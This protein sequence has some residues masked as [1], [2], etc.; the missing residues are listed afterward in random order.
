M[1]QATHHIRR[2]EES[3]KRPGR[4]VLLG[5]MLDAT[6]RRTVPIRRAFLQTPKQA[7]NAPRN[8]PLSRLVR[9]P[10]ALDAYLLIHAM[11][12]ASEPYDTWYPVPT[13]AQVCGLTEYAELPA[14]R[15]RWAK[16]VTRLEREQ[17]IARSRSGNRMA[18]LLR[19]ESGSGGPYTRPIAAEHGH[20]F[21][22]PHVYWLHEFDR[23]LSTPEKVMLLISLDQQDDFRLPAD[24]A[25]AWYGISESTA[26][27]GFH[28]LA[29]RGILDVRS[30]ME[31][32]AKS[33][34]GWKETLYY[35]ATGDWS[36]EA[37]TK[38]NSRKT[39]MFTNTTAK[40]PKPRK[41]KK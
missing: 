29:E 18:Y 21:S 2:A 1:E 41:K 6:N 4:L 40:S 36:R 32:E 37:R 3:P 27:R 23:Q 33:P 7:G 15:S 10:A 28:G 9:D 12:S 19:H 26:R 16:I 35:T 8:G 31:P 14:A 22:L 39:V 11:A 34:T 5:Q 30:T 17:L 38:V 13:W 20:W 24:R 25:P